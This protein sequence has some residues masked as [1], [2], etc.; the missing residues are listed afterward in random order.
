MKKVYLVYGDTCFDSY[1]A[2]INIFGIFDTLEMAEKVKKEKE[3]EY[4]E[5]ESAKYFSDVEC[6]SDIKFEIKE[7]VMNEVIDESLGGYG[8]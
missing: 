6:R 7:I 3:D 2:F 8:E 1:G 5:Y 4:Y